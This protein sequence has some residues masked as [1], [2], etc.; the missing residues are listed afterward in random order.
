MKELDFTRYFGSNLEKIMSLL[1]ILSSDHCKIAQVVQALNQSFNG[2]ASQLIAHES[3]IPAYEIQK[4]KALVRN[5]VIER[6]DQKDI[7]TMK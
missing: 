6:M 3:S 2:F 1:R 7:F 4:R 5:P